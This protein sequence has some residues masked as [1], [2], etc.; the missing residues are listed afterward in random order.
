MVQNENDFLNVVEG[1]SKLQHGNTAELVGYCV[2]HE[3]RLLVYKYLSRGTL[4]ELLH[5]S[6]DNNKG[7]SWNMRVKI[8]LGAARALECVTRVPLTILVI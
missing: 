5:A 6:E 3:Q 2:E 1:L 8:A 7:L 4:H